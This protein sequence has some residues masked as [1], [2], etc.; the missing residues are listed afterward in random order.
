MSIATTASRSGD[1]SAANLLLFGGT[2]EQALRLPIQ[3]IEQ[4][5]AQED[6]GCDPHRI[7]FYQDLASMVALQRQNK[8]WSQGEIFVHVVSMQRFV[9]M[10]QIA[11]SSCEFLILT[12]EGYKDVVT[13]YRF[14]QDELVSL[15]QGYLA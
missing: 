4:L 8:A 14:E 1:A 13:A 11:P 5:L 15:I 10:K 12:H 2:D 7:C 9:I 3:V 6:E